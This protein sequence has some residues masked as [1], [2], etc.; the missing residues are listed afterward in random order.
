MTTVNTTN[1]TPPDYYAPFASDLNLYCYADGSVITPSVCLNTSFASDGSGVSLTSAGK[2]VFPSTILNDSTGWTISW[3]ANIPSTYVNWRMLVAS[4]SYFYFG[5]NNDTQNLSF[6]WVEGGVQKALSCGTFTFGVHKFAITYTKASNTITIYMDGLLIRSGTVVLN[7]ALLTSVGIGCFADGSYPAV[8]ITQRDFYIYDTDLSASTIGA[9]HLNNAGVF[10]DWNDSDITWDN[11]DNVVN[12]TFNTYYSTQ[13]WTQINENITTVDKIIKDITNVEKETLHLSDSPRFNMS[14]LRKETITL[15]EV[16]TDIIGYILRVYEN[17]RLAESNQKVI[18]TKLYDAF[19]L[20]DDI[21]NGVSINKFEAVHLDDKAIKSISNIIKDAIHFADDET[22][23]FGKV[24]KEVIDINDTT[25]PT[26]NISKFTSEQIRF[27]ENY[28]DIITFV[29]KFYE[30]VHIDEWNKKD[31]TKNRF[32]NISVT[33]DNKIAK[34]FIKKLFDSMKLTDSWNR[35]LNINR[36][37]DEQIQIVEKCAKQYGLNMYEAVKIIDV[38]IRHAN[39]I[40]SDLTII[41]EELTLDS[42]DMFQSPALY[43]KFK[44]FM[45]GDYNYQ[46][47]LVRVI[48]ESTI[49]SPDR[50][51]VNQW[52][53]NVDVPDISDRGTAQLTTTNQPLFVYFNPDRKFNVQ[54]EI[55]LTLKAGTTLGAIPFIGEVTTEGFYAELKNSAG[56]FVAG[57]ISW[58]ADGY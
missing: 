39:A 31:F 18:D 35:T 14:I 36:T 45:V 56:N 44:D 41:N 55:N 16:Y 25:K 38:Y 23:S 48:L 49:T 22:H 27:L 8:G 1:T 57:E 5:I 11:V 6:S 17:I 3:T 32:E 54:P 19:S 9:M 20:V 21:V 47:A 15:A 53:L 12:Y 52:T 46:E 13:Y 37:F 28:T 34:V 30:S 43:D 4:W 50:P 24:V 10:L 26:F 29:L 42:F 51:V 33:D 7:P 40:I 58:A 2:F